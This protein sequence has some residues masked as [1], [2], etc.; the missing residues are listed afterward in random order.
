MNVFDI[1]P[2]STYIGNGGVSKKVKKISME[3]DGTLTV[4]WRRVAGNKNNRDIPLN[5]TEPI[6]QFA[7]WAKLLIETWSKDLA[8]HLRS[9]NSVSD[10]NL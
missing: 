2:R 6:E 10:S 4:E 1:R 8:H 9:Q 7:L 3:V 5:G